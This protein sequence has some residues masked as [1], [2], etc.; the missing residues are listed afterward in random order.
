MRLSKNFK[1]DEFACKCGC[2]LAVPHPLLIEKLQ[3][4]R[5]K[6]GKAIIVNS[7]TRCLKH[8][9]AV[10]GATQSYH[11]PGKSNATGI[12][13]A[14]I[15]RKDFSMAADIRASGLSSLTVAKAAKA[16]GFT[17]VIV[18]PTFTHVDIRQ[19]SY[20]KGV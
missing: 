8:N 17:G 19:M 2:G 1:S 7:G 6:L 11:L 12:C 4:L 3:E 13:S 16:V 10:G 15:H 18:Y 20:F 5:N 14:C 9:K